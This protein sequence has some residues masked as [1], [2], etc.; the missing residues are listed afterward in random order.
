MRTNSAIA[1]LVKGTSY[2]VIGWMAISSGAI[3]VVAYGCLMVAVTKM[4]SEG[5]TDAVS[6]IFRAHDFGVAIQLLF[7]IPLVI[8]LKLLSHQAAQDRHSSTLNMGVVA[9]LMTALLLLFIFVKLVSD[10]LYMFPLGAFG[11]W[12]IVVNWQLQEMLPAWLRYLGIFSGVGLL[13]LGIYICGYVMFIDTIILQI[14]AAPI[15]EHPETFSA[16]N[17]FLHQVL[18]IGSV[19][20]VA[21]LPA[22]TALTG[23][24][25][26]TEN[27]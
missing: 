11:V 12:L 23:W 8:E 9:I 6:H 4:F 26:L 5:Y 7:M 16:I 2:R 24:R 3:G 21:T 25:L 15:D 20:G 10:T 14:P 13:L 18:S 22:W 27:G 1:A 17:T 19:M